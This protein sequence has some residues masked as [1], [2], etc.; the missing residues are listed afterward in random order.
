MSAQPAEPSPAGAADRPQLRREVL[1]LAVPAFLALVA[2]PVF[3]L[4][5]AAIVGHLG[6]AQ[7]AGL[8]IAGAVVQTAAGL[9]VFLAYGTTASVARR[10]GAGDQLGALRQG[11]DGL[12]LAALIGTV[13]TAAG[14]LATGRL[15][16]LFDAAPAAGGYATT[17]L[18]WAFLGLVPM[19]AMMAATG[20]VRGLQD[21]R[22]PLLVAVVGNLANVGLNLLLV[23]G[24]GWGIAGSAIG[25]VLA[26]LGSAGALVTVVVRGARRVG[27]P[28]VPDLAGV[29]RA[30][31]AGV[32]LVVRTLTLRAALLVATY[33]SA[34]LGVTATATHQVA[35]TLWNLLA[36]ALDALA[37]AAQALT[38]RALGAGDVDGTRSMTTLMVRWGAGAG[39]L[40]GLLLAA[41]APFLGALF[42]SD[43]AVRH[44]LVPVLLVAALTQPIAGVVFVLDGVLIGAGDGRYLAWGGVV[45]L[46]VFVPLAWLAVAGPASLTWLW[47]AFGVGF[48]GA[49]AVVLLHR[50]RTDRW[51][52]TGGW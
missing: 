18:R 32:A 23:Y 24:L 46:A 36:F 2:E 26:Q 33:G 17:Y 16:A 52:V 1:R 14:L 45:V 8:G 47:A 12:W 31:H 41:A 49:R 44:L 40:G 30:A 13:A 3:L 35:M 5:D 48:I 22:T 28:L 39:V 51:L 11:V 27:A 43:P 4:A 21:T 9:C 15:V 19:L 34:A 7:L 10:L 50:A 29:R 42:T 25:T 6:T 38:G 20:V 37:I